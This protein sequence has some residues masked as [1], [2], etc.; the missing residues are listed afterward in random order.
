MIKLEEPLDRFAPRMLFAPAPTPLDQS[1]LINP[2]DLVTRP[3]S[4]YEDR[5]SS[6]LASSL[7]S[8]SNYEELDEWKPSVRPQRPPHKKSFSSED[9]HDQ[10]LEDRTKRGFTKPENANCACDTCG[11]LF[12]RSYNLKAHMETHDPQRSQPHACPYVGCDKRFVRR[13]DLLRHEQSV[14][15]HM[16]LL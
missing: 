15:P 8:P 12:Q 16:R 9:I 7:N 14:R 2:G 10:L 6:S 13:T 1:M 11:K 5:L 3:P 4:T